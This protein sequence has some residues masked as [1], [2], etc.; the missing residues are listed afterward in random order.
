[1]IQQQ[2]ISIKKLYHGEDHMQDVFT[3]V[4]RA[5]RVAIH[6]AGIW[7]AIAA[8]ALVL[9]NG[10]ARAQAQ[11][12]PQ[13]FTF[14]S[15]LSTGSANWCIDIPGAQY[16]PGLQLVVADCTG[17]P[18]QTWGAEGGGALTAGGLCLDGQP[19]SARGTAGVAECD[20]S[21]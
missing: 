8:A 16:R 1:M 4:G 21:G 2:K 3:A 13:Y 20:G 11:E 18:N 17:A 6:Q 15:V 9:A 19:P 5:R 10:S 7:I 14:K 12:A